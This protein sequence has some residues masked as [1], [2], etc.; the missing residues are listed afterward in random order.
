MG[1]TELIEHEWDYLLTFLPPAA[2]L[3]DSS[4]TWGALRRKRSVKSG[5]DLLR[6]AL[7]YGFCGMSLRQT[8][9]WAEAAGVASLSDVAL[10]NRLRGGA[11]WLGYLLGRK[12]AERAEVAIGRY[13]GFR[14]RLLD[15]TTLS[16]P[17]SKGT[18][19]RVHLSLD[20][21][22]LA[23]DE[24]EVTDVSGGEKLQRFEFRPGEIV[25]AD[26][27]YSHRKGIYATW[28][29]GADL[30][31]RTNWRDLPMLDAEGEPF[32]VIAAIRSI[33]D[34]EA[35][36]FEVQTKPTR[37]TPGVTGRFVA[38]R[39]TEAAAAEG[40]RRVL[41]ERSKKSRTVDPRTLEA[42]GYIF[43]FTT[44]DAARAPAANVLELHRYRWLVE[45]AFK[46]LKSILDLDELL[47][48]DR[49]L[50][51]AFI[52]SKLLGALLVDE[53]TRAFLDVS[54][55]GYPLRPSTA[56]LANPPRDSR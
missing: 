9:A 6:L 44:L 5:S 47:A 24:L 3:D 39:K 4:K 52:Y 13:T 51:R 29:A 1:D 19:W 15:A 43:L 38:I 28:K 14:V 34:A 2:E 31:V 30:V 10:L 11:D 48:R 56:A 17:G 12:L 40:R 45:L 26:A 49:R 36:S 18:D 21:G 32:D 53:L 54:P 46:R 25:L 55:W 16:R 23:I 50:A 33:P 27:G 7:A 35:C 42:A 8:T 37:E 22:S 41:R 20:L